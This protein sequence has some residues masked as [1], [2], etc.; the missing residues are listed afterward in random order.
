MN[1][2]HSQVISAGKK[3]WTWSGSGGHEEFLARH[4]HTADPD[5]RCQGYSTSRRRL[6]ERAA[7][8]STGLVH[9]RRS[10]SAISSGASSALSNYGFFKWHDKTKQSCSLAGLVWDAASKYKAWIVNQT[11]AHH[12][13]TVFFFL[14]MHY[15]WTIFV[16][17]GWVTNTR[18]QKMLGNWNRLDSTPW[19][20]GKLIVPDLES[21]LCCVWIPIRCMGSL[22]ISLFCFWVV[23]RNY[24]RAI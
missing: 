13:F 6:L 23:H 10:L 21:A 16:I 19:A 11:L 3:K 9:F 7:L 4:S 20:Y 15:G 24:K 18:H 2:S 22:F 8:L 17:A 14:Y 12:F 5:W 1:K